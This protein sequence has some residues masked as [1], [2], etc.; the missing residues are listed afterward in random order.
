VCEVSSEHETV[1][2]R[3][4]KLLPKERLEELYLKR[5][6]TTREIAKMFGVS[7]KYI[8][9]LL[10]EYD[11][12]RV[13]GRGKKWSEREVKILMELYPKGKID[14]IAKLTGRTPLAIVAKASRL[15]LKKHV[16]ESPDVSKLDK[17]EIAWLAGLIDGDGTIT[18]VQ[19]NKNKDGYRYYL[20]CL[21]I[22]NTDS[23]VIYHI[24]KIFAKAGIRFD[25]QEIDPQKN[26][27]DR[28]RK[29]NLRP[30]MRI[31][32]KGIKSAYP[33][34][35][36]MIPYLASKKKR[37][38]ELV[39]RFCEIRLYKLFAKQ[40]TER[41]YSNVELE[42]IKEVK[43]LNKRNKKVSWGVGLC[44]SSG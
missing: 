5:G 24:V 14:E 3:L 20:P 18:L 15:G 22:A 27:R 23:E 32:V 33:I 35:K 1:L 4:R 39:T 41:G 13:V 2:E 43:E 16:L 8:C 31:E 12:P 17:T 44:V 29:W 40:S 42:I 37:I 34:V 11:I 36:A 6:F 28:T 25:I 38:A 19:N 7:H 10:D 9:R 26:Y 21:S 30:L